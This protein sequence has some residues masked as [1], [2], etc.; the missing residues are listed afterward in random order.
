[1]KYSALERLVGLAFWALGVLCLLNLNDLA[2]MWIGVQGAAVVPML[3]CCLLALSGLIWIRPR[4]ALGIPG[5]LVL[6]C[7]VSYACIGTVVAVLSGSDPRPH[8]EW[9]YL[10]RSAKS[11]LVITAAAVGGG[12]LLRRIGGDR[13]LLGLLMIMTASC[14]LI[15]TSPWLAVVF[16][17]PPIDAAFRLFG[18]FSDPNMAGLLACLAVVAA[19][20]VIRSGRFRVFAYGGLLVAAAALVGTFSRTALVVFPVIMFGALLASRGVQLK[21]MAVGMA[22]VG[23]VVAGTLAS[24]DVEAVDERQLTRW[25]SLLG[26]IDVQ[27]QAD[28]PI[29]DRSVLWSL[30]LEEALEAP[31]LGNGLGHAH[32]LDGA[33]YNIDGVLLGA[34]NQYLI[35][36]AEAGF[37]PL[38]SL[39]LFFVVAVQAGF[40]SDSASYLLGAVTGW[41]LVL[42]LFSL[43]FHGILELR[44]CNFIIGVSCAVM[45]SCSRRDG[46]RPKTA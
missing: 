44:A 12:V 30:A 37:L 33:W 16:R 1:M 23:L 25:E 34:H 38:L 42:G 14:A 31:L 27:G 39:C 46:P 43:T 40:R 26:F 8:N 32:H 5:A 6:L 9:W 28:L 10:V 22:V 41:V 7:V 13:V 3:I 45:A 24:L 18:S 4:E 11:V 35:L 15:L 2:R 19:L 29:G 20:A 21:R 17:L 36:A